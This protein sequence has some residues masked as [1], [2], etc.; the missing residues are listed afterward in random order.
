MDRGAARGAPPVCWRR[1]ARS[2]SF[3]PRALSTG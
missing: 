3:K 1:V 2:E